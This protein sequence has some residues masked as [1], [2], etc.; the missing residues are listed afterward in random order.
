MDTTGI[1]PNDPTWRRVIAWAETRKADCQSSLLSQ[2][3]TREQDLYLKGK[4]TIF[5]ELLS[6]DKTIRERGTHE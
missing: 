5:G 4:A 3:N 6:L 1:D 2:S